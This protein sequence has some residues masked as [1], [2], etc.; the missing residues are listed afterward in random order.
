[1]GLVTTVT[2]GLAVIGAIIATGLLMLY[3]QS[4]KRVRA[5][6]TMSLIF[7]ALFM[8]LQNVLFVYTFITNMESLTDL[9]MT[10][11]VVITA[12]G[13]FALALLFLNSR[14]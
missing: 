5:P 9:V 10:Y 11:M 1:M 6:F 13:D 12:F 8:M 14:K 4:Y 2:I 3:F 7:V